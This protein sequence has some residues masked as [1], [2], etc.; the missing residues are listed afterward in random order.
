MPIEATFADPLRNVAAI[1][2][3]T[4]CG[5]DVSGKKP[6]GNECS[7][8]DFSGSQGG[9]RIIFVSALFE[10]SVAN[11]VNCDNLEEHSGGSLR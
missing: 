4:P 3:G 9:L 1:T 5:F 10:N 11:I 2:Q 7:G 8:H 6:C